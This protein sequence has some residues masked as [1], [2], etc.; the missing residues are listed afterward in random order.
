MTAATLRLAREPLRVPHDVDDAGVTTAG[1]DDEPAPG[2][3]HHDRLVVEDQRVGLPAA[4][5]VRLVSQEAGLERRRAI[6]LARHEHR[7]VEQERRL[8]FLDDLEARALER[9]AAGRGQLGRA[10]GPGWRSADAAR[11]RDG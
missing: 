7:P 6:D 3:A 9:G 11:R 5:D 1:E 2:E 10:R 8:S 4:V